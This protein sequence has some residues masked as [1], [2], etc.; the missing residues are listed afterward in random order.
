[1]NE[2]NK[3]HQLID[4]LIILNYANREK[5]LFNAKSIDPVKYALYF[6][7]VKC[8]IGRG[9]GKTEYIKNRATKNDLIITPFATSLEYFRDALCDVLYANLEIIRNRTNN[10]ND[11][12]DVIY[13]DESEAAFEK[14]SKLELYMLLVKPN[15]KQTFVL[16]G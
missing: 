8:D 10:G 3:F 15:K 11:V 2:T 5:D 13:V 1:M 16:L 4:E 14:I 7:T 9:S 12:F 6:C